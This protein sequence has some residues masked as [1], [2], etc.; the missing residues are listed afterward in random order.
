MNNTHR[1]I[2]YIQ[3]NYPI[4]WGPYNGELSD[5]NGYSS[6]IEYEVREGILMDTYFEDGIEGNSISDLPDGYY[7]IL[8]TDYMEVEGGWEEP[9]YEY[10]VIDCIQFI[11]TSNKWTIYR[12][13]QQ[14][15]KKI[16][17]ISKLGYDILFTKN[18]KVECL[19]ITPDGTPVLGYTPQSEISFIKAL[20]FVIKYKIKAVDIEEELWFA[21]EC[22]KLQIR[23][24][25]W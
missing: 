21:K 20:I 3:D 8:A 25:T 1:Q 24:D 18:W 11:L 14:L 9:Y 6:L 10:P 2:V 22:R 15:Y 4:W 16:I 5:Y 12:K 17:W 19:A 23:R 13:F 7:K